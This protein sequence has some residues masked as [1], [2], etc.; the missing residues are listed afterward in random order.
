MSAHFKLSKSLPLKSI[1][2]NTLEE[3]P[4][5]HGPL[6]V[7]PEKLDALSEEEQCTFFA[8]YTELKILYLQHW[9][10]ISKNVLRCISITFGEYLVEVDF[11]FSAMTY[12]HLE[13]LLV[14]AE[15]LQI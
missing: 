6:D 15:K 7:S 9:M 8:C 3:Y 10:N 14:R 13:A 1:V 11:S 12:A 4:T 5:I 2:R